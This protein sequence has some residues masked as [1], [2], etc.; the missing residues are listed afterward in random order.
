MRDPRMLQQ[1]CRQQIISMAREGAEFVVIYCSSLSSVLDIAALQSDAAIPVITPLDVYQRVAGHYS[2]IAL[3]AAN[4]AGLRGAET[5]ILRENPRA[6]VMGL[7]SIR[8]VYQIE[9][10]IPAGQIV[11]DNQLAEFVKMADTADSEV[12]VLACTHFPCLTP[13]LSALTSLPLVDMN[14]GLAERLSEI[15]SQSVA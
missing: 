1:R 2:R 8:L 10:G 15:R 13:A 12:I 9:Q 3:L 7:Q 4:A 11:R 14:I 5:A 6:Q